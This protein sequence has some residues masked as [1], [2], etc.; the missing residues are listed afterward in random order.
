MKEVKVNFDLTFDELRMAVSNTIGSMNRD[1]TEFAARGVT[2]VDIDAFETQG[3]EFEVFPSD[4]YYQSMVS[5]EVDLK[6]TARTNCEQMMRKISGYVQQE[7]GL[8]SPKY[9]RLGMKDYQN[10]RD[11]S[12]LFKAREVARVAEDYLADLTAI[13]LTQTM[14]DDLVAEAQT[15][16]DK[17]N[18]VNSKIELRDE[19]T[20]ERVTKANALYANLR[21]YCD[22][23][24]LIWEDIDEA[25]YKD[26]V[27]YHS[28]QGSLPKPQ[29]LTAGI[30]IGDPQLVDLAWDAV[31]GATSYKIYYSKVDKDTSSGTY[32]ELEE[33]FGVETTTS[34]YDSQKR[35]YWKVRAFGNGQSSAYSDEVFIQT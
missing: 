31:A 11:S 30:N 4:N 17:M 20:Q 14:I 5:E 15:M 26:Y 29:N 7:W 35:N 3:N 18:A 22:I 23:G 33:V 16:E 8:R 34:S 28:S 2:Q 13:G 6:N 1:A 27:I 12:F 32:I 9:K 19:K 21:K 25:K 10:T 24:K